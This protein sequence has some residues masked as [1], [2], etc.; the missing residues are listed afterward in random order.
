MIKGVYI[1][2]DNEVQCFYP[3]VHEIKTDLETTCD[4]VEE[5]EWRIDLEEER[6]K[7]LLRTNK[8]SHSV[9]RE[10]K[11]INVLLAESMLKNTETERDSYL[12]KDC[13]Q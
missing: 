2:E 12:H 1:D 13:R 11:I 10:Y 6:T 9:L 5:F 8:Q 3:V 4:F 7:G